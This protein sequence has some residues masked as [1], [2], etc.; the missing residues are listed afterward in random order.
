[1]TRKPKAIS[2]RQLQAA[3]KTAL[4]TAKK[5]HPQFSIDPPDPSGNIPVICRPW[6]ILGIPVPW[7]LRPTE[8]AQAVQFSSAFSRTL[9]ANT[10]IAGLGIEGKIE[11]ALYVAGA[12]ATIGVV[13]GDITVTE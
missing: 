6:W 9:A 13:T 1:M 12:E 3:V 10:Q 7:P 11:P 8:V 4:E 5:E 2:I